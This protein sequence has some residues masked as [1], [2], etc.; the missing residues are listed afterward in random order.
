MGLVDES[1]RAGLRGEEGSDMFTFDVDDVSEGT[2]STSVS[3]GFSS[4]KLSM[5]MF[6]LCVSSGQLK[7]F[8]S[9]SVR[10]GSASPI[11]TRPTG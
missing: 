1:I 11:R 3:N 7:S 8:V 2:R 5:S 10:Y 9:R 4:S 6:Q